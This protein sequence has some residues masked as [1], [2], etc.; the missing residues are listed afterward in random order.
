MKRL[1]DYHKCGVCT[2]IAILASA[3]VAASSSGASLYGSDSNGNLVLINTN[4]GVGTLIGME[5]AFPLSTEIEYDIANGILYSEEHSGNINL[6]VISTATGLSTGF[7]MHQPGSIN[8]M[9]FI[10]GQL[11]GTYIPTSGGL[12]TLEII[13]P[14]TG[15]FTTIGPTGTGPITGL[16][17]DPATG[18]VYG[19]IGAG[20]PGV[21]VTMNLAT[22]AAI[23]G[24]VVIDSASGNPI[25]HIGSIEYA[26]NGVLYGATGNNSNIN[27]G[28]LFS[29]N[30]M[31]G[32]AT[33]IGPTGL[34]GITGLTNGTPPGPPPTLLGSDAFGNIFQ[35]NTTT[36]NAMLI[37][38][39][40]AFPLSTEIEVDPAVGKLYSH[41]AYFGPHLHYLNA[42]TGLSVSSVIH[43]PMSFNGMEFINNSLYATNIPGPGGPSTLEIIDPNTGLMA[44]IGPTG[45]GPISGLA[46]DVNSGI[47]Y[48]VTAGGTPAILVSIN[49]ATGTAVP[50]PALFD[51]V[52]GIQLVHVGSIEFDANGVLW[53]GMGNN[54]NINPGW[55]FTINPLNGACTFIGPTGFQGITGL[56]DP[57]S[58][59]TGD[60]NGDRVVDV[61]DISYVLFRLPTSP[62]PGPPGCAGDVNLDGLVDVNDI[63][64]V[65]F[66][67][68]KHCP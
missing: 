1:C 20:Q 39:E 8:G 50:G 49:L 33:F 34:G 60:A 24:P 3:V 62:C 28:W 56:A 58:V 5:P 35:I 41:E 57:T 29:V 10:Q 51:F 63:S 9:E 46:H 53:G 61:N 54:A 17:E 27:P 37:G 64:Y 16:A 65:L 59:C 48:G 55:V 2:A 43:P 32:L 6:H 67:L 42:W 66:R 30:P 52:S 21:V 11:Y 68:G 36:G 13:N 40:P 26:S 38:N 22:G 23:L 25:T 14:V 15:M 12:S 47:T 45:F 31:S 18:T 44:T 19:V 4:T 7:V